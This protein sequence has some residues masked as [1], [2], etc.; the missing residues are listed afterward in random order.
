SIAE[1]RREFVH[2]SAEM[3]V[4]VVL[5]AHVAVEVQR[6]LESR[7]RRVPR[8]PM[9][10]VHLRPAIDAARIA[11]AQRGPRAPVHHVRATQIA[12]VIPRESGGWA[13]E[14]RLEARDP[15]AVF[16]ELDLFGVP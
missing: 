14:A 5:E 15:T 6:I 3:D 8:L 9:V 4:P 2:G 11:E 1:T 16:P 10:S 7:T 12:D 13:Q